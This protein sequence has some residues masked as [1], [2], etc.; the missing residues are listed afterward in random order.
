MPRDLTPAA[1]ACR[2]DEQELVRAKGETLNDND[3]F[4]KRVACIERDHVMLGHRWVTTAGY[5]P[6]S[7]R[8]A[9]AVQSFQPH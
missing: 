4:V 5:P 3:Y 8:G 6:T 2:G 1:R 9:R 7:Q